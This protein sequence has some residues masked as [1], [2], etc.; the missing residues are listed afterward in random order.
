MRWKRNLGVG[1]STGLSYPFAILPENKW[2]VGYV[3]NTHFHWRV[4]TYAGHPTM[5]AIQA[6]MVSPLPYP[7]A[8]YMDGANNGNP[9]PH[10]ERRKAT[11][12]RAEAACKVNVSMT[13]VW[14][15]WKLRI[16][17]APT[18]AM[19]CKSRVITN[20]PSHMVEMKNVQCLVQSSGRWS[21]RSSL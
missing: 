8:A 6:K 2:S 4:E 13:Y 9:N 18:K 12:A 21:E 3:S 19:P 11:A 15:D 10:N 17:P 16:T 1:V 20:S 5:I 14:M 7:R